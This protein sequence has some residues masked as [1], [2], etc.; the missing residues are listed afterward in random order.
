MLLAEAADDHAAFRRVWGWTRDHLQLR[1]GLFAFH[2][3]AAG[4]VISR[5]PASD[6]DL[7][8]AWAL[9]PVSRSRGGGF[10]QAGRRVA[11]AI[12]A[13]EVIRGP[14]GTPVL[15]AGP[16][17]TGRPA[18][19][20]PSYWSLAALQGL[21]QLTGQQEWR[22]LASGAVTFTRQLT[23]DGRLLPPDWA[24]LTAAGALNQ[25]RLRT[26]A[27]RRPSSARTRSAQS[28]GSQHPPIRGPGRCGRAATGE[29]LAGSRPAPRRHRGRRHGRAAP[30]RGVRRR[31]EG[32]G[33]AAAAG[34][35]LD[36]AATQQRS[37][38]TYYGGAWLALGRALLLSG[39]LGTCLMAQ[40][41]LPAS[42]SCCGN[43]G[44][45]AVGWLAA[46]LRPVMAAA[47]GVRRG[48]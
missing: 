28:S 11:Q 18:S 20:D 2:A 48:I 9:L 7:I 34:H 45:A 3:N 40:K 8:I 17:A 15:T 27:S 23:R 42:R 47:V 25:N 5:E 46:E 38:P 16:W 44:P 6:A 13:R 24:Q 22:S 1:S 12:L 35:L 30:A 29:P 26:A 36:R 32:A 31:G 14:G 4:Q 41:E 37:H 19:L 39:A 10:H 21:A 43:L 33:K